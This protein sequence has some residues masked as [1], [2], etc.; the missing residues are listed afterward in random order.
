M[1]VM[2]IDMSICCTV[3]DDDDSDV[4]MSDW[5]DMVRK[6]N[7]L[8]REES[9]LIYRLPCV[10]LSDFVLRMHRLLMS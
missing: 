5:L 3:A 6:K 4:I 1:A 2:L 10:L 7:E 8:V 9:E